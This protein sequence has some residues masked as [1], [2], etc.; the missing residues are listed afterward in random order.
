[1]DTTPQSIPIDLEA[2]LLE[3]WTVVPSSIVVSRQAVVQ[4][5]RTRACESLCN[6]IWEPGPQ[7]FRI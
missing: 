1:M 2:L 3:R 4:A 5:G 7:A 6:P